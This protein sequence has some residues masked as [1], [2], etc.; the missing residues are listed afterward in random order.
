M[1]CKEKVKKAGKNKAL[2]QIKFQN[3]I[4]SNGSYICIVKNGSCKNGTRRPSIK[5]K[6]PKE[7]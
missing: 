3:F 4:S 2:I 6:Q 7:T 5:Q 1:M